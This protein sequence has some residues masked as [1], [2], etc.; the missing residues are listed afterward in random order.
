MTVSYVGRVF[1]LLAEKLRIRIAKRTVVS[2]GLL[3]TLKFRIGEYAMAAG[4][5]CNKITTP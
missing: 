2:Y 5:K 3:P 4:V 1:H